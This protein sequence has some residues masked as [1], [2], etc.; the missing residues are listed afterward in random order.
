MDCGETEWAHKEHEKKEW[1]ECEK[2]KAEHK[3]EE[4][5]KEKCV[6]E[7]AKA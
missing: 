3:H 5:A 1:E 6:L 4:A 2:H 7:E